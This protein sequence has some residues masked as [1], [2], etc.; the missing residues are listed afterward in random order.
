[1]IEFDKNMYGDTPEEFKSLVS[2]A[3]QVDEHVHIKKKRTVIAFAFIL[4]LMLA[5][6]AI[7]LTYGGSIVS[8][9]HHL[10]RSDDA[11]KN[12]ITTEVIQV[13]GQLESAAF[14]AREASFDGRIARVAIAHTPTAKNTIT[15]KCSNLGIYPSQNEDPEADV[16]LGM[17]LA[18]VAEANQYGDKVIGTDVWL[19]E[20]TDENDNALE[21][22]DYCW[23]NE[24]RD[25]NSV[26]DVW[27]FVLAEDIHIEKVKLKFSVNVSLP[28]M[29]G[30]YE[31]YSES[32][33]LVIEIP[34]TID[35]TIVS[36]ATDMVYDTMQIRQVA[37]RYTPYEM[38]LFLEVEMASGDTIPKDLMFFFTD[39]YRALRFECGGSYDL[40][41][42]NKVKTFSIVEATNEL[43]EILYAQSH[44]TDKALRINIMER[45]I[46]VVDAIDIPF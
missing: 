30:T 13:G 43:P 28:Q 44:K 41:S 22:G 37:L 46:E 10:N 16:T 9:L 14:V 17:P 36:F 5:A 32:G 40:N 33:E 18:Q 45:S 19:I 23:S 12:M 31:T 8:A 35:P 20:V 26:I 21:F 29:D 42:G 27:G 2:K 7:A 1:M 3:V 39:D 25:E 24:L 11:S 38:G 15:I 4:I 34:I 6:T